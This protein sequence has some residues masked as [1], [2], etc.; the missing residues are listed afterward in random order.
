[1]ERRNSPFQ[2]SKQNK[3]EEGP[4]SF[5]TDTIGKTPLLKGDLCLL[6]SSKGGSR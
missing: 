6:G 4:V 5:I 1:M 3:Q 2:E